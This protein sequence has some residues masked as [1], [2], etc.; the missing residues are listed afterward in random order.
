[1]ISTTTTTPSESAA[2]NTTGSDLRLSSINNMGDKA[3]APDKPTFL[4]L[5]TEVRLMIYESV[6]RAENMPQTRGGYL[7]PGTSFRAETAS[8]LLAL[9]L[10]CK[11][12]HDETKDL[13]LCGLLQILS[14]SSEQ[15]SRRNYVKAESWNSI[16]QYQRVSFNVSVEPLSPRE[17]I[18]S[19]LCSVRLVVECMRRSTKLQ[20]LSFTI[21]ASNDT[22]QVQRKQYAQRR[23]T[24]RDG[25]KA[26]RNTLQ[27]ELDYAI[28]AIDLVE[29]ECDRIKQ[30]EQQ[31]LAKSQESEEERRAARSF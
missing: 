6:P 10:V 11:Q 2:M 1:M 16:L 21:A 5:P 4:S 9:T 23:A 3:K 18:T 28:K 30:E 19:L 17:D 14:W 12:I 29:S 15:Q 25:V 13:V 8:Q 7:S 27:R 24:I 20:Y 22:H 31:R 26:G